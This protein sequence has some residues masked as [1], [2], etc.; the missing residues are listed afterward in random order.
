MITK[1]D[2]EYY[3]IKESVSGD[4]VCD[5]CGGRTMKNTTHM[6]FSDRFVNDGYC[7]DCGNPISISTKRSKEDMAYWGDL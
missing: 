1:G 5:K 4:L 6:D 2:S 3:G 7:P